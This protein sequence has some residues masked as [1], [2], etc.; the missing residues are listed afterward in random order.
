[1]SKAIISLKINR[2]NSFSGVD[3]ISSISL[4]VNRLGEK[5]SM[6]FKKMIVLHDN[7]EIAK[8]KLSEVKN[9]IEEFSNSESQDIERIHSENLKKYL[10]S[11]L[12]DLEEIYL[13]SGFSDFE[14]QMLSIESLFYL[15]GSYKLNL[16][17]SLDFQD[18]DSDFLF[19]QSNLKK[20]F[21]YI[22]QK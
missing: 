1:M 7:Y 11:I 5:S 18:K 6:E 4:L 22:S 9:H 8:E 3:S 17:N 16:F 20:F 13:V 19:C 15:F 21:S 2:I 10:D 12:S 14:E